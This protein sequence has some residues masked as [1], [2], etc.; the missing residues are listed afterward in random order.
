M[1]I[2]AQQISVTLGWESRPFRR[3]QNLEFRVGDNVT[4][5]KSQGA[6]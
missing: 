6:H 1:Q 2:T 5:H 3:W 4:F